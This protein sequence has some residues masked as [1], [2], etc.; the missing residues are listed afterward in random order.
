MVAIKEILNAM[1][2]TPSA[3]AIITTLLLIIWV[4]VKKISDQLIKQ[5]KA[6]R[7]ELKKT[8]DEIKRD[9]KAVKE[10]DKKQNKGLIQLI[11][12]Q[13]LAEALKWK[14]KGYIDNNAKIQF[15]FQWQH[16]VDLGDG[17]GDEPRKIVDDLEIRM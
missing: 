6:D 2:L 14:E 10:E 8:L 17:F 12:H 16:Y 13:C 15:N 1:G 5:A 4:G 11:Y 7:E 9:I 3:I